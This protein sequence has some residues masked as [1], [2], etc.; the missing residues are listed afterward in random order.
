M[1]TGKL[2]GSPR[3]LNRMEVWLFA[4][5]AAL[6]LLGFMSTLS[7][8]DIRGEGSGDEFV[9]SLLAQEK[10]EELLRQPLTLGPVTGALAGLGSG[11]TGTFRITPGSGDPSP[12]HAR[13]TV[14]IRWTPDGAPPRTV[15]LEAIRGE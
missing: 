11:F 6:G 10:L 12:R 4:T 7:S 9:A 5:I 13:I 1:N 8:G 2:Q 14:S 3:G 15:T